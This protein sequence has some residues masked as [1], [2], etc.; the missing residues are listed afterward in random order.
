MLIKTRALPTCPNLTTSSATEHTGSAHFP[1]IPCLLILPPK[2]L[3]SIN[4]SLTSPPAFPTDTSQ[5]ASAVF[6]TGGSKQT[7]AEPR[8]S[9]FHT[10]PPSNVAEVP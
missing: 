1:P 3:N 7:L 4:C 9:P 6:P 8:V 2:N 10:N 5:N